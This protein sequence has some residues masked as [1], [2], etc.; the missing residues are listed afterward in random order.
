MN[1]V[2]FTEAELLVLP[3]RDVRVFIGTNKINTNVKSERITTGLTQV[4][5]KTDMI[6]HTHDNEEEIIFVIK[7]TG[8]VIIGGITEKLEPYTAA[9]FPIGVEHQVKNIGDSTL[10]FVF[11]FNPVFSFGR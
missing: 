11:M 4:P 1:T 10:E 7:G 2:K 9:K 8:E 6:P 3:K 5:S